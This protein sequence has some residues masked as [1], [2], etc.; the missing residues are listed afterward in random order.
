MVPG[1]APLLAGDVC[2]SE[3]RISSVTNTD[4]GKAV[5]VTG[6]VTRDGKPI[7][8]VTSAFLYRGRF[9]DFNQTFDII[10]EKDH[11]VEF[12]APAE[13]AVLLSKEWFQ[14][15]DDAKPFQAGTKLIFRVT[16]ELVYNDKASYSSLKVKGR[17]FVRNQLKELIQVATVRYTAGRSFGNP[18]TAYLQRHGTALDQPVLFENGGY[19]LTSSAAPSTFR[20]PSTNEPYSKISRD[21][22]P[23]HVNPYFSDFASLP[24]TITHGMWSS[25]A[26]RKFV[27]TVAAKGNPDRVLA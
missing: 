21:F 16:S 10:Q 6:F 2:K 5:K 23:I 11:L 4:A 20:A 12:E 25:A 14:W 19:T 27:E 8:E 15:D 9:T 26:T 7:I 18:V 17:A 24:A 3:A 22:N 1:A 13:V